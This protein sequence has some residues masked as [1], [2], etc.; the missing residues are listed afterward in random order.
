M[1]RAVFPGSFDPI[2]L[3]HVDI[4]KRGVSFF[5]EII[6]AIGI[7]AAKKYMFSLEKRKHF[8]EQVFKDDATIKIMTYEGLTVNFCKSQNADFILRGLRNTADFEYEKSIAQAN[9]KLAGIETVFLFSSPDI[10]YIS[11]SI[12]RDV[13]QNGG[14]ASAMLPDGLSL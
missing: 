10:S 9:Y 4:I 8:L 12:V 5:D 1:K 13:L 14:D 7:N 3:G 2:T 6:I 11:S